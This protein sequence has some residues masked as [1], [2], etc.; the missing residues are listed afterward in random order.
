MK[1]W[2]IMLAF[3]M[4]LL[5]GCVK[6]AE[7]TEVITEESNTEEPEP[8]T[9]EALETV[10][11]KDAEIGDIVQMGT[12]EQDG[13]AETEDPICWDVL[14]KD[15][16]AVLLISYDVIAYQRFSDSRKC[17][18]W[19]D[20]EIRTWLNQEFY[21]EAFDETE[22]ASIR[23][24]T[25]EN[26]STVGFAAHV[27]P[28]G[29]VQVRESRPD[30]KD[31]IFLLSWKEAEQYYG[32]RLT[33]ASILGRRPSR[34]VLQKRKAIFTDLIIEELPA[35]YPYSR[36]LPDGT[37]RLSWMLRSTGM[38]NYTIFVIGYEGKWDQDYPDSYNGVRPVMW[39]NVGD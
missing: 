29:D 24:T 23:E 3:A 17:V 9:T 6:Q 32:N 10:T 28:S 26:P 30:T 34:A 4:L 33:D 39:V 14:D 35:M 31:K 8:A 27:D 15:G 2:Y 12:Y 16:D 11:L 5:S 1:K 13:D 7:S 38:K 37:E 22:Q 21:A 19:E 18:I 36:H 25:L 20:S